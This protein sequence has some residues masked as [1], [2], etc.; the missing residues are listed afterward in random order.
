MEWDIEVKRM[1]RDYKYKQHSIGNL[2][3]EIASLEDDLQSIRSATSDATP[4]KGGGNAREDRML[5][6]IVKREELKRNLKSVTGEV[7]RIDSAMQALSEQDQE[8]LE[9]CY[10]S[11]MKGYIERL[12]DELRLKDESSVHRRKREALRRFTLAYYGVEKS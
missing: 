3:K 9:R 12:Q 11:P 7:E 6:N 5:N 4:V 2:P 8:L 10:I 1:L